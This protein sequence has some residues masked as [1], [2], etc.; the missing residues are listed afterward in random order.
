MENSSRIQ[1]TFIS[2]IF[3]ALFHIVV[4]WVVSRPIFIESS[5]VGSPLQVVFI[6]RPRTKQPVAKT[7]IARVVAVQVRKVASVARSEP[8]L[9]KADHAV[10]QSKPTLVVGDDT[11]DRPT[12]T[13]ADGITFVHNPLTSSYN[14]RP[15]PTPGRFRMQRQLSP[16]DIIRGVSQVLGFWPPGYTDDPCAGLDKAV[17]MFMPARTHREQGLLAD[18]LRERDKYCK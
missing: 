13:S 7:D 1:D 12:P 18:A 6:Q 10:L 16:E 8:L 9:S 11:W 14:P 4:V 2:W 5:N 15:M 3:V 17:E